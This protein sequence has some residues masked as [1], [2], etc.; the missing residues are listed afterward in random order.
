MK[1]T[2]IEPKPVKV[3]TVG[4]LLGGLASAVFFWIW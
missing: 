1:T 2:K 3:V 4:V